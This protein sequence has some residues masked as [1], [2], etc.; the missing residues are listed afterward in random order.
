[1]NAVD[2]AAAIS[3]SQQGD[4]QAFNRLVEQYQARVY[5]VCYWLLDD[6]HAAEDASQEVFLSAFRAI[7]RFHG[8]SFVAWLMA[9]AKNKCY[10]LLRAR[11]RLVSLEM[12]Q[13]DAEGASS[14]MM[15]RSE[16]PE[17]RV[18]RAELGHA[19]ER[20]LLALPA[21]QRL[22][23]VLRDVQGYSYPEIVA[24]TGWPD[25]TIKSRL[26]RGRARLR[27]ALQ[28]AAVEEAPRA[29]QAALITA[30]G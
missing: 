13:E 2:E 27:S 26:S 18:L 12:T 29:H 6:T 24:A 7:R 20:L 8:G 3:R 22:V 11:R 16:A 17:E 1:M 19:L 4:V 15:D 23:I 25:G 28:T 14:V 10:D 21:D 5:G 30:K 9:I